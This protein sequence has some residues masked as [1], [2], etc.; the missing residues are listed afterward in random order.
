[1]WLY[2]APQAGREQ[3]GRRPG[4]VLS[5]RAY[6][7]AAGLAVICPIT[8]KRKGYQFEVALPEAGSVTGVVL[9]DH[10]RSVDWIERNVENAGRVDIRTL[11]AVLARLAPLLGYS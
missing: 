11:D 4:L 1:V 9:V 2:F 7:I 5:P 8:S 6:N 10:I 3:S